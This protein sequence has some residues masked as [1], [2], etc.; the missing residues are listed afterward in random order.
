VSQRFA[1]A[2]TA[3]VILGVAPHA[4]SAADTVITRHDS[5]SIV[6]PAASTLRYRSTDSEGTAK[7][8]GRILLSGNYYYTAEKYGDDVSVALH[9]VPDRETKSRLPR[10]KEHGL[11]ADIYVTNVEAFAK[12]V[13]AGKHP[14]AQSGHIR[15][16]ADRYE[17][18]I[19]C[20]VPFFNARFVEIV[21][22]AM[23][24]AR[25]DTEEEGC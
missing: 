6:I 22:P 18:G 23:K 15:I 25:K 19:E 13:F 9:L 12:A 17:A 8:D 4:V 16:W 7:F 11:A 3:L 1:A 24:L 10:F 21:Q 5:D 2:L 20:D 14:K